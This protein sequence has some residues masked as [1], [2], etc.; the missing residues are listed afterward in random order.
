MSKKE[1]NCNVMIKGAVDHRLHMPYQ[2]HLFVPKSYM[3][4]THL[5]CQ[6]YE[7]FFV[8]PYYRYNLIPLVLTWQ[9]IKT[10][11]F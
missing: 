8:S 6:R 11:S 9:P 5:P 10:S 2:L 1:G 7:L 4:Q 3:P